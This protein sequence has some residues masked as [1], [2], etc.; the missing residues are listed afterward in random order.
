VEEACRSLPDFD[1]QSAEEPEQKI[2]KLKEYAQQSRSIIEKMRV[3]HEAQV[4]ELQLR[5][6]PETPPYLREQRVSDIRA[7]AQKISDLVVSASK[8]LDESLT[9]WET[10]QENPEAQKLQDLI[11]QRQAELEQVK[12]EIKTMPPAQK[13]VKLKQSKALQEEIDAC[14]KKETVLAEAAQPHIDQALAFS[15]EAETHLAEL[16][17]Y[18]AFAQEKVK[19]FSAEALQAI[20]EKETAADDLFRRLNQQYK[21][22]T[23]RAQQQGVPGRDTSES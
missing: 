23:E 14:K 15:S 3:E 5:I 6:R 22:F 12:A 21:E 4:A 13:I 16:R 9:A 10:L 18:E 7:S 1:L 17:G 11:K 8:L 20:V 19:E 2:E